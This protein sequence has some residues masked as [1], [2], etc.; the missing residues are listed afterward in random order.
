MKIYECVCVTRERVTRLMLKSPGGIH[1]RRGPYHPSVWSG[2]VVTVLPGV[3]RVSLLKSLLMLLPAVILYDGGCFLCMPFSDNVI[4][5]RFE[6][7]QMWGWISWVLRKTRGG[8]F[9]FHP[10]EETLLT[11]YDSLKCSFEVE[12]FISIL[13]KFYFSIK[14]PLVS[15]KSLRSYKLYVQKCKLLMPITLMMM[16]MMMTG[17]LP[18]GVTVRRNTFRSINFSN[19]I[20]KCVREGRW[21]KGGHDHTF[22]SSPLSQEAR[23]Q[24]PWGP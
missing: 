9:N 5:W 17:C 22:A 20:R 19:P 1:H 24:P 15:F 13:L 2:S 8:G 21:Y 6:M 14:M 16:L 12:L 7:Q 23:G 4:C 18:F 11:V 3:F 10:N